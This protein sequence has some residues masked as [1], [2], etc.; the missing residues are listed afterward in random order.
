MSEGSG[1]NNGI[2]GRSFSNRYLG[3]E[4]KLRESDSANI[5]R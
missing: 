3:M 2:D 4:N 5:L 1:Y